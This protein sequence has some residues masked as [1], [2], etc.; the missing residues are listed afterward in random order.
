MKRGEKREALGDIG[1]SSSTNF[2]EVAAS[3]PGSC[4]DRGGFVDEGISER[5]DDM[6]FSPDVVTIVECPSG[7]GSGTREP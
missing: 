6:D 5:F 1:V 3:I 4:M 7:S 2:W